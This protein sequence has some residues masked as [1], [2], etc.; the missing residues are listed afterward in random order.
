MAAT[1]CNGRS[2]STARPGRG[3]RAIAALYHDGKVRGVV[4]QNIDNLHQASG[5]SHD[6]VIELH[7]NTTY[8][9]CLDCARR[10][11]LA[12]VRERYEATGHAPN[13]PA[14]DGYI[15]TATISF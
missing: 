7:G 1:I 9:T 8:A 10:Y 12:F 4:T 3:H 14:C 6:D 15:K 2:I 5:I 11:E 13:C